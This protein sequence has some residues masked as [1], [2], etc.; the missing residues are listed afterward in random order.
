MVKIPVPTG[1]SSSLPE[2]CSGIPDNAFFQ[3]GIAF[4]LI[5]I[6]NQAAHRFSAQGR[7]GDHAII[8]IVAA[9]QP[10]GAANCFFS[11][12]SSS[13][14]ISPLFHHNAQTALFG[15]VI[16]HRNR[17]LLFPAPDRKTG[18]SQFVSFIIPSGRLLPEIGKAVDGRGLS[19]RCNPAYSPG[20]NLQTAVPRGKLA[21]SGNGKNTPHIPDLS[22][23]EPGFCDHLHRR[24][25]WRIKDQNP[26]PGKHLPSPA[27][28]P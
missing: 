24:P 14:T 3:I 17:L 16:L 22:R 21:A 9:C 8:K 2:K 7:A 15:F 11:P 19:G 13:C 10:I 1:T 5:H 23:L 12:C 25:A 4:R 18:S 20:W 26:K 6:P 27:P 28:A